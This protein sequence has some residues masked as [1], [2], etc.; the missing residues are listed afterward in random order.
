MKEITKNKKAYF[1][2][3]IMEEVEAGIILT[4]A[5]IKSVRGGNVNL[6]GAYIGEIEGGLAIKNMHISPFAQMDV[7]QDPVRER[8]ILLHKKEIDKL[9]GNLK[10]KNLTVI[11]LKLILKKGYAKL[12]LG[13][14]K[15]RKKHDKR[16]VLKKR[17]QNMEIRRAHTN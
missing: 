12:L 7:K 10:E 16:E 2:Y 1:D 9:K 17:D 6:T 5:E 3:E 11:P 14:C 13:I 15:G 4:G 8:G